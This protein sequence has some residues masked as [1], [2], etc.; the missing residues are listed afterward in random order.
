MGGDF[1]KSTPIDA[2]ALRNITL[3]SLFES[4]KDLFDRI[5]QSCKESAQKKHATNCVFIIIGQGPSGLSSQ[6]RSCLAQKLQNLDFEVQWGNMRTAKP[7]ERLL[8]VYNKKAK[9][10]LN[11][12]PGNR[13]PVRTA[14]YYY[15]KGKREL[16][17]L[18]QKQG[19]IISNNTNKLKLDLINMLKAQDRQLG[20]VNCNVH[21][22][23]IFWG[24]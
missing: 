16:V 1:D 2:E 4:I 17:E 24:N 21:P 14:S 5:L 12:E 9:D 23:T 7:A 11:I 20:S 22:L 3:E 15:G 19:Q 10:F 8:G 6:Q 18:L 13:L